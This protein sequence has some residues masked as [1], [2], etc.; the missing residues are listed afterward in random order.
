MKMRPLSPEVAASVNKLSALL[1]EII[2]QVG[3]KRGGHFPENDP[4]KPKIS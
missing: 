1:A 2:I 4:K 3:E